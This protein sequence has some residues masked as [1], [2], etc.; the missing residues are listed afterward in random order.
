MREMRGKIYWY[1]FICMMQ[2][3]LTAINI[4]INIYYPKNATVITKLV[5]IFWVYFFNRKNWTKQKS[6]YL[7]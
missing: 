1:L 2:K 3:T 6:Q 7:Y 5:S 4:E